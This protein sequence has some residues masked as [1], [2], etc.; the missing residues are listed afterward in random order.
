MIQKILKTNTFIEFFF[1]LTVLSNLQ[2]FPRIIFSFVK[3]YEQL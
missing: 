2:I 3:E 1:I